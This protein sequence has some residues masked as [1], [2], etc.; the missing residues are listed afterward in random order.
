MFPKNVVGSEMKHLF[1]EEFKN[2]RVKKIENIFGRDWFCGKSILELGAAH[3]DVGLHFLKLGAEVIFTDIREEYL[4]S[5][6]DKVKDLNYTAYTLQIDQNKRYDLGH[7]F[8]LVIHM[9][10]LYYLE[11]WKQD[12]ECAMKHT[13]CMILDTHLN[14]EGIAFTQDDVEGH[15]KDLGCKFIRLDTSDLNTDWSW[16]TNGQM[17]KHKYDWTYESLEY[18]KPNS[19]FLNSQLPPKYGVWF[20]RFWMVLK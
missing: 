11:N 9:A 17:I 19:N 15:L 3:G 7:K 5:I 2:K 8:D 13:D 10:V 12:L 6:K 1:Y 18:Q 4:Q 14:K 20:R 16:L